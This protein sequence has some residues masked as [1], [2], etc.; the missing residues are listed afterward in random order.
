MDL[1]FAA[2]APAPDALVLLLAVLVL[3]ALL[4]MRIRPRG[5]AARPFRLFVRATA[6]LERRLNRPGRSRG[7]RL[8]RGTA[9]VALLLTGAGAIGWAVD[10]VAA[11]VPYGWVLL[12]VALAAGISMRRPGEETGAV[13]RG[14][15]LGLGSGRDAASRILGSQSASLDEAGM[16]RASVAYLAAHYTDG[17]VAAV[18]WFAL[19]GLP[20]LFAYRAA[21]VAG[22][23]LPDEAEKFAE[24]GLTAS[25]LNHALLI[26]PALLAGALL[27]V[28]AA[29]APGGGPGGAF[30][31]MRN[32]P[33]DQRPSVLRWPVGAFAGALE[34]ADAPAQVGHLPR[35]VFLYGIACLL[36]FAT[37]VGF[38]LLRFMA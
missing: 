32:P 37:I 21:N 29:F 17:L 34:L 2:F 7:K 27:V 4:P 6:E 25:R 24:F 30:R 26:L 15:G 28:A 35:A 10:E 38:A 16:V 1:S 33:A 9:V 18:F 31:G 13:S 8:F 23:L 12:A 5:L 20:G 22:R 3:D 14:L 11:A 36:V 19:L